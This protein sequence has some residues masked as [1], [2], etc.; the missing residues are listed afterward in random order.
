MAIKYSGIECELR[1]VI[2]KHKPEAMVRASP[3]G[4]VPVLILG[5]Y[6]IDESIDV[7]RWALQNNNPDDWAISELEHLLVQRNDEYF[8]A[9][10]DRYKYF[11][12][13]PQASQ[14][15]YFEKA[16]VFLDELESSMVCSS[17]GEY[18]LLDSKLSSVDLAIFPFVR[19][20][21]FVDKDAFDSLQLV[22]LQNWL[23]LMLNADLFLSIMPKL[24]AWSP[25]D[26]QKHYV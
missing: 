10:L 24:P 26:N 9:Y 12:R 23:E 1:E 25:G 2:L 18:Y 21:A 15:A 11:E 14:R 22:K 17:S 4:T 16:L 3:K 19:Q 7:M 8:K 20:F 5:E 6:V 13:Y